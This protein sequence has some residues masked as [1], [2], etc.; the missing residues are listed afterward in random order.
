LAENNRLEEICR[1]YA[2][3]YKHLKKIVEEKG[4]KLEQQQGN[5]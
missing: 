3:K 1:R 2:S 5:L 4:I